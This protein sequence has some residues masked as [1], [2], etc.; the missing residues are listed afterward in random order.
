L[1]WSARGQWQSDAGCL[2]RAPV[3]VTGRG[4]DTQRAQRAQS[5]ATIT[6]PSTTA[7][8]T[9]PGQRWWVCGLAA[10]VGMFVRGGGPSRSR[11]RLRAAEGA[12]ARRA[13]RP[14]R[15][16]P[17]KTAASPRRSGAAPRQAIGWPAAT[18]AR[19]LGGR[20]HRSSPLPDT[21]RDTGMPNAV[22]TLTARA[23]Q[24]PAVPKAGWQTA[25]SLLPSGGVRSRKLHRRRPQVTGTHFPR[26][27]CAPAAPHSTLAVWCG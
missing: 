24:G 7:H 6:L 22:K 1:G 10:V 15:P 12:K 4:H 8:A 5:H 19:Q 18:L 16:T 27:A 21:T 9:P 11:R 14:N 26:D 20:R 3:T 13:K 23:P 2:P 17:R 25:L